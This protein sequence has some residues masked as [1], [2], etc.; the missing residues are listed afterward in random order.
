MGNSR[1]SFRSPKEGIWVSPSLPSP[2]LV[3]RTERYMSRYTSGVKCISKR[4]L[5][6]PRLRLCLCACVWEHSVLLFPS[7]SDVWLFL[8]V[9]SLS[10]A[11]GWVQL[12]VFFSLSVVYLCACTSARPLLSLSVSLSFPDVSTRR[13]SRTETHTQRLQS[14]SLDK[15]PR[16]PL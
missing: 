8:A 10:R 9:C 15:I 1:S 2:P 16:I 13:R 12:L 14:Y 4:F 7:R 6:R 11:F 3:Q 5:N